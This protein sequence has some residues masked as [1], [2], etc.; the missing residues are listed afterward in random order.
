MAGRGRHSADD[1]LAAG[2]ARGL[3]IR[4]AAAAAK[5]SER[6]AHRRNKD[7]RFRERVSEL[8]REMLSAAAGRPAGW[9]APPECCGRCS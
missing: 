6:T 4:D 2:L 7:P 3:T 8:R 1:R 9:L 5:V